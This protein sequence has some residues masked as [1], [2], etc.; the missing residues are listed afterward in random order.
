MNPSQML[1]ERLRQLTD[2]VEVFLVESPHNNYKPKP[3]EGFFAMRS[4]KR[5]VFLPLDGGKTP[6]PITMQVQLDTGEFVSMPLDY[7]KTLHND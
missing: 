3:P 6:S 7:A 5:R 1:T 2:N 4:H